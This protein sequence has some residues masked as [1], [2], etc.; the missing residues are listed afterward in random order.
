MPSSA[1]NNGVV[2]CGSSV[3]ATSSNCRNEYLYTTTPTS[4]KT[5]KGTRTAVTTAAGSAAHAA[6]AAAT[7]T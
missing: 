7:T 2:V 6:T 1:A 5:D 3:F 4:S